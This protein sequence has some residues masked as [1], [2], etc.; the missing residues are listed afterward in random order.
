MAKCSQ[1]TPL[2][3]KGLM[4][5]RNAYFS[6]ALQCVIGLVVL[7]VNSKKSMRRRVNFS[8]QASLTASTPPCLPMAPQVNSISYLLTYL[9]TY[10][11]R[12]SCD[13][14]IYQRLLVYMYVITYWLILLIL[15]ALILDS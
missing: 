2:P 10:Y 8:F 13:I 1:L 3:F 9:L 12:I 11:T 14:E 5:S 7:N 4:Q 15:T 6:D